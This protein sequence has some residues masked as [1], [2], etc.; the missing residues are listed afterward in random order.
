MGVAGRFGER[1][2]AIR[3]HGGVD[4]ELEKLDTTT[5]AQVA[6]EIEGEKA[7]VARFGE[8]GVEVG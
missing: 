7:G 2:G 6:L 3:G 8:D 5:K 4:A 1:G